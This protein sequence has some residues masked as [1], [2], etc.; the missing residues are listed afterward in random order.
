MS[1]TITILGLDKLQPGVAAG[2]ATLAREVRT[3]MV[4]GSK[5]VEGT[6][7][8]LAPR[9][10]GETVNSVATTITG[11]GAALTANIGPRSPHA[12]WAIKGRPPGK[13]PPIAAIEPWARAKGIDP[14]VLARSIGR[15]GTKGKDFVTPSLERNEG[16][17]RALFAN[18]GEV[19]VRVMAG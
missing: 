9:F 11:G 3:A 15:K 8:E 16:R 10:T 12:R 17:I 18:V 1:A 5:L 6:Q 13:Q 4:A 7:R 14:F 19:V 2:P